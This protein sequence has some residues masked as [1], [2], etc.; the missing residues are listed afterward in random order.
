MLTV[1]KDFLLEP[2]LV[3]TGLLVVPAFLLLLLCHRRTSGEAKGVSLSRLLLGTTT[4]GIV[5]IMVILC[6]FSATVLTGYE[7]YEFATWPVLAVVWAGIGH[8]F[9]QLG[10]A[11]WL[12]G[13]LVAL[14]AFALDSYVTVAILFE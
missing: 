4:G 6:L 2:A 9:L 10:W 11:S 5:T 7:A 14:A 3:T 12:A 8:G 1:I 13:A